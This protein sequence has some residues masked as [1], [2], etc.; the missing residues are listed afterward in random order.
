MLR[1]WDL[2]LFSSKIFLNKPKHVE[3]SNFRWIFSSI[4]T[5]WLQYF[6]QTIYNVELVV[7][8]W[9]F[10][11]SRN[12][13]LIFLEFP[14]LRRIHHRRLCLRRTLKEMKWSFDRNIFG[15]WNDGKLLATNKQRESQDTNTTAFCSFFVCFVFASFCC[16]AECNEYI[17]FNNFLMNFL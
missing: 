12:W 4:F 9:T 3:T 17:S 5:N 11:S 7:S 14:S 10:H 15:G 2:P 6:F 13:K 8:S 16:C 1:C